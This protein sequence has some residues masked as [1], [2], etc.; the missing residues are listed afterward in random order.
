M[1][2][3]YWT[4]WTA[5]A[6]P[7]ETIPFDK[8]THINYAFSIVTPD[9]RPVFETGYLLDR[10]VRAAHAK[11]VKVLMSIGGWTGSQYFSPLAATEHGRRTFID[12]AIKMV[13]DYNLDGI[14]ID[15]EYPGRLG[16]A[17]NQF[18]TQNDAKNFLILLQELRGALNALPNGNKLEISLATRILP[19]DG[20]NGLLTDVREYSKVVNHINIMA[21]D[22]NGSWSP[23]TGANAPFKGGDELSYVGGAQA[24]IEAG[25]P[26]QQINMGVPFYGRSLITKTDMSHTQTMAVPFRK[27][28]PPGDN[29][30]GL[31]TDPC[32]RTTAYSG[33]WKYKNLREQGIIDGN[34]QAR[35]PW[36]RKFDQDSQTPWLF[37]PETKQFVSYDDSESLRL[38]VE[39]AKRTDLGGVMLWALN[40][41]T[42]DSELL[43]VLQEM[44]H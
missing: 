23:L 2:V 41:D 38:K 1:V 13:K 28:V 39:Y 36:I 40:Q 31:W 4:D 21:Y 12:G 27:S 7:P 6:M 30:D 18:D 24:W 15:W 32:E 11:N 25:F 22:I 43:N 20:P 42:T 37:N 17:C 14:D 33:V 3:A 19:F 9:F 8:V 34:G 44:R 26:A 35:A 5:A 29:N 16:S 10:V